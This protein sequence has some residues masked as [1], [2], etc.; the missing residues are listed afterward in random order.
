MTQRVHNSGDYYSALHII[1]EYV[2]TELSQ[3]AGTQSQKKQVKKENPE[4]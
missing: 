4:R 3:D 2:E 1:S